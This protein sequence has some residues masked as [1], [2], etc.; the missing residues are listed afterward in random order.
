MAN[1]P[2]TS[3]SP[4]GTRDR[5]VWGKCRCTPCRKANRDYGEELMREHLYGRFDRMVDAAPVAAHLRALSAAGI[6]Y[7]RVSE[8]A[9]LNTKTPKT[10][11]V[12]QRE[13]CRKEVAAAILAIPVDP[14]TYGH[15]GATMTAV[16]SVRRILAL[17]AIGYTLTELA[18]RV[19]LTLNELSAITTQRR[20]RSRIKVARAR[21]IH[22]LYEELWD[23]PTGNERAKR[24]ART[25]EWAPPLA[26]DEDTINDPAASP[27]F[28]ERTRANGGK[29]E[30]MLWVLEGGGGWEE[31]VRRGGYA[32]LHGA[33]MAAHRV[34]RPDIVAMLPEPRTVE[35]TWRKS[36]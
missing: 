25:R 3:V 17:C 9:Q 19:G 22:A 16:G 34:G 11:A 35:K 12:G 31:A 15:P 1:F 26:W 27:D 24:L 33:R 30:D 5:Y 8:I 29:F 2:R 21:K 18:P 7:E 28:G 10:I 32:S 14:L 13:R 20:G 4:H 6:S 36:A 23:K